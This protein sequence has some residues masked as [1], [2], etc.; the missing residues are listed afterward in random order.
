MA[1]DMKD[2]SIANDIDG[3]SKEW[4]AFYWQ[5]GWNSMATKIT[6]KK[7]HASKRN[8]K[9]LYDMK[10]FGWHERCIIGTRHEFWMDSKNGSIFVCFRART[11]LCILSCR[12]ICLHTLGSIVFHQKGE[13]CC[14]KLQ[15]Y[16][17]DSS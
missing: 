11:A 4:N 12:R 1:D 8:I 17:Y 5:R 7:M 10:C 14:N 13:G 3:N 6:E 15:Y 16:D 2:Y 9:I